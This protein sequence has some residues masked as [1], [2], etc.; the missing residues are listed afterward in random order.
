MRGGFLG[1][2]HHLRKVSIFVYGKSHMETWKP[3]AK[4]RVDSGVSWFH[5]WKLFVVWKPKVSIGFL[6]GFHPEEG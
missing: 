5:A 3:S 1:G 2:F 4:S 6:G